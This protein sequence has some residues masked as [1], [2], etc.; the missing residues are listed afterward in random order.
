MTFE[1]ELQEI[2]NSGVRFILRPHFG[3]FLV[4]V[5]D[6]QG[7][8]EAEAIL[9]TKEEAVSWLREQVKARCPESDYAKGLSTN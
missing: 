2:Q 3:R 1:R 6:Y 4:R 5:G 7:K 8:L 9:P